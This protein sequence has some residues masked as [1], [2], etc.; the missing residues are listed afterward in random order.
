MEYE[1][2]HDETMEGGFW[3]GA[4]LVPK[5]GK[6]WLV[7]KLRYCRKLFDYQFPLGIKNVKGRG[8]TINYRAAS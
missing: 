4:L 6:S 3:H 2:Y 5:S 8:K 1:I 7:E